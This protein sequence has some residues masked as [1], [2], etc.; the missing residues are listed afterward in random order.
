MRRC[1]G[2]KLRLLLWIVAS[3][4]LA[5]CFGHTWP[6]RGMSVDLARASAPP[7][8]VVGVVEH[9]L[10]AHG[11]KDMGKGG[12]DKIEGERTS[13]SFER[14]D[15]LIVVIDL[16]RES[17]VPIRINQNRKTFSPEASEIFD[18]VAS[19]LESLW[20]GSVTVEAGPAK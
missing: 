16:D 14:P 9:V 20:P 11:F 18:N 8:D 1:G 17:V 10:I 2:A 4:P 13:L 6:S 7:A 19:A 15:D 12:R 5:A 3:V